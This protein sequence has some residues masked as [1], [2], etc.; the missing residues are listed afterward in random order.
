MIQLVFYLF[1]FVQGIVCSFTPPE[2][3]TKEQLGTNVGVPYTEAPVRFFVAENHKAG[4]F[5]LQR[6]DQ[7]ETNMYYL[8][9]IVG[10]F[11][12]NDYSIQVSRIDIIIS[13]DKM[14]KNNPAREKR[15]FGGTHERVLVSRSL[16]G[17]SFMALGICAMKTQTPNIY[18][19]YSHVY[20]KQ[21]YG[22]FDLTKEEFLEWKKP[23]H[24]YKYSI[25][26]D[27]T[28]HPDAIV[29]ANVFGTIC[30][31]HIPIE[32]FMKGTMEYYDP[33]DETGVIYETEKSTLIKGPKLEAPSGYRYVYPLFSVDAA[34]RTLNFLMVNL[35]GEVDVR[36]DSWRFKFRGR[37]QPL[38]YERVDL[39]NDHFP[40]HRNKK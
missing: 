32:E 21:R 30:E 35:Q 9:D 25:Y 38:K 7:Y 2:F 27:E 36:I 3:L 4:V 23:F 22:C 31:S 16:Y 10:Y 17:N 34:A 33:R 15:L 12:N 6:P 5:A 28:A 19:S 18:E 20:W 8:Q 11:G 29:F 40:Q 14:D 37:N 24:R 13:K 1:L 39:T 26:L